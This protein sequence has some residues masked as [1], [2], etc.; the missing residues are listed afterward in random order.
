[1]PNLNNVQLMGNL[2]RDVE[3]KYTPSNTAVANIGMA[4]NRTWFN[5]QTNEKQEETTFVDLEAWGKAAEALNQYVKR[6]DP[7]FI[8][9]RLK[10]DS[11]DDKQ[12]GQ[13]RSKMKIVIES[14]EFLKSK[15]DEP[16]H[17]PRQAVDYTA[18]GPHTPVDDQDIPF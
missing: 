6:G 12:N 1:M 3:L 5:K 17:K 9:G 13:K 10:L 18:K 16:Q 15:K 2:T 11:W 7:L 8:Q 4:I 14:F